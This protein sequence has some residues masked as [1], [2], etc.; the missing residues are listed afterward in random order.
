MMAFTSF[1]SACAPT[2]KW[3]FTITGIDQSGNPRFC[4]S[5]QPQCAGPGVKATFFTVYG[6]QPGTNENHIFWA[7]RATDDVLL[8]RFD[9]G[10]TP[11]GYREARA[12]EPLQANVVYSVGPYWFKQMGE[13]PR[14][15]SAPAHQLK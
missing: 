4:V 13:P 9:Y 2:P 6:V 8:H 14:Y 5:M 7:I 3:H 15:E 10:T 12:A 11:T 1:A